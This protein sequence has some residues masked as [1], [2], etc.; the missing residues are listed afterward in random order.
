[1]QIKEVFR[2]NFFE[3]CYA[4]PVFL[5]HQKQQ[6]V[7]LVNT[8]SRQVKTHFL[9]NTSCTLFNDKL[10]ILKSHFIDLKKHFY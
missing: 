3:L 10:L 4:L 7:V 1:M 6:N 2:F 9:T 8:V 5:T